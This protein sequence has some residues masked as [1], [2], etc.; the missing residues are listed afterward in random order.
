[1]TD[2]FVDGIGRARALEH[3]V[4]AFVAVEP[5]HRVDRVLLRHVDHV[6][7]AELAAALEPVIAR[8]GQD[9]GLRA[10][11]LGDRYAETPDRSGPQPA[12]ISTVTR[13]P[14]RYSSTAG[15]SATTVPMYS[16]PGV[17]FLLCG[18]PPRIS[19]GGP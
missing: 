11:R 5:A 18:M 3:V 16:C 4:E 9:D 6:V 19:A 12:W 8:P 10:D 13:W 15:P 1:H 14:I 17:K 2:R 7:R